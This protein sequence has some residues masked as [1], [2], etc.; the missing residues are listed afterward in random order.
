MMVE[1]SRQEPNDAEE[2]RRK[3]DPSSAA[4]AYL[5][6]AVCALLCLSVGAVAQAGSLYIGLAVTEVLLIAFPAV[7]YVRLKR[8]PALE[9]LRVRRVPAGVAARCGVLGVLGW[10]MA[11]GLVLATA[12][13]VEAVLG[14]SP[15][16]DL[17]IRDL[18][19]TFSEF[20]A[21]LLV[22]ALLPGVCEE[23]LFRG[24][25]QGTVEKKGAGRGIV[26]TALLFATFHLN[27]WGF[28]AL[29]ALGLVLGVVVVR[30]NST[31]AAMI[32]HGSVNAT[33][34]IALFI[35]GGDLEHAR[36]WL[37]PIGILGVLFMFAFV[38]F[39]YKT[40]SAP[41]R[42]SLLMDVPAYL[43]RRLRWVVVGSSVGFVFV[44]L[45]VLLTMVG[46]YTMTTDQLAPEIKRGDRV[47]VLKR[48]LFDGNVTSGDVVAFKRN[49]VTHL[50]KVCCVDGDK[51]WLVEKRS[52]DE[53][54]ETLISRN[55]VI[56][57]M[58]YR[59]GLSK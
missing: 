58:V 24:A 48:P 51:I 35:F 55:A 40:R 4:D 44:V 37:L 9:A 8:L 30:T 17:W 33:A 10:G 7:V 22:L 49:R 27:P 25:I 19:T 23:L 46:R 13:V 16:M 11:M 56:G 3:G 31:A 43:S 20:A 12:P 41:R 45:A 54:Y 32:L 18:P 52:D 5:L 15:R 28:A 57:K 59:F 53:P 6:F 21:A 26:Y 1:F 42:P 47:V 29:L 2:I 34:F 50:R 39:L 38:E 36:K 14:P